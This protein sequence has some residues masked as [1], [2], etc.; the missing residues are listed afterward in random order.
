MAGQIFYP[1]FICNVCSNLDWTI[2]YLSTTTTLS[3]VQ[4]L[5][6][7]FV[8]CILDFIH[9]PNY[10]L[11]KHVFHVIVCPTLDLLSPLS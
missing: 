1:V 3:I 7:V 11:Y 9:K 5:F 4:Q 6:A 2:N 10:D 8:R